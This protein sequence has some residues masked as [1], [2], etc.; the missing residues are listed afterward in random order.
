MT[1]GYV[2]VLDST[3]YNGGTPDLSLGSEGGDYCKIKFKEDWKDS[4]KGAPKIRALFGGTGYG[5]KDGKIPAGAEKFTFTGTV[6]S[7]DE[8]DK[9]K[10]YFKKHMKSGSNDDYIFVPLTDAPTY[11]M[12]YDQSDAAKNGAPG[13]FVKRDF[14]WSEGDESGIFECKIE[15]IIVW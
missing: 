10:N 5:I 1:P 15:F 9:I 3:V 12:F 11:W 6:E 2:Y 14:A 4:A 13:F 7:A 8:T